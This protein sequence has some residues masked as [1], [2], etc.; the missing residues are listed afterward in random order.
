[1]NTAVRAGV[2]QMVAM[3]TGMN[4]ATSFSIDPTIHRGYIAQI[5]L[6]QS[7]NWQILKL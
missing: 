2:T 3:T 5:Y 1:M 6:Q 7:K 4:K